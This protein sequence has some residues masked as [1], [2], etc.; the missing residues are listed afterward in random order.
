MREAESVKKD[1]EVSTQMQDHPTRN[2]V[3]LT[4]GHIQLPIV[5]YVPVPYDEET[6]QATQI[7]ESFIAHDMR[8]SLHH[9]LRHAALNVIRQV[10]DYR[11]SPAEASGANARRLETPPVP[12]PPIDVAASSSAT[13][14]QKAETEPEREIDTADT[15]R[16]GSHYLLTGLTLF[17][18]HEPCIMCAMALLHSRVKEVFYAVPM[19]K[20][21][22]CGSVACVPK[23]PNVNHR[24]GIARW[25]VGRGVGTEGIWVEESCD[26]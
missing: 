15:P 19:E 10:A 5:A 3:R 25:K 21:G 14:A 4:W 20:T 26:A 11:A 22:G 6:R 23:L 9:P 16:N 7:A 18:T 24:Y 17:T 2:D 1:G 8:N 13:L 12:T